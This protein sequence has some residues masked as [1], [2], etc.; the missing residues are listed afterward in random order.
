M[1]RRPIVGGAEAAVTRGLAKAENV[2]AYPEKRVML[3][4]KL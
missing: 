2:R 3:E 4:A 1:S